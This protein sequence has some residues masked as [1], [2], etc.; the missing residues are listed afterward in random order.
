MGTFDTAAVLPPTLSNP[1]PPYRH[2]ALTSPHG[3]R[4][5]SVGEAAGTH[6]SACTNSTLTSCSGVWASVMGTGD[7]A[8][9]L[10]PTLTNPNPPYQHPAL[11][12]PRGNNVGTRG[13]PNGQPHTAAP[14]LPPTVPSASSAFS[15]YLEMMAIATAHL[16][17]RNTHF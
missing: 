2:P 6:M 9:V 14:A 11:S 17:G 16:C 8:A 5:L 3:S 7:T 10:Q 15:A 4:V 13:G 1:N 12:S